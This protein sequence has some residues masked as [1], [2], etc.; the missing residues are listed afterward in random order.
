M[1]ARER[2]HSLGH[3]WDSIPT[4][5]ED[6]PAYGIAYLLRCVHCATVRR[7]VLSRVTGDLIHRR[8][9]YEDEYRKRKDEG[10]VT[11]SEWRARWVLT[12][13]DA[14]RTLGEEREPGDDGKVER[15]IPLEAQARGGRRRRDAA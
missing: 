9:R 14:L 2:C 11:R 12:L 4:G 8:Y 10:I 3:S 1:S 15:A 13:D 5:P 7:D 6:R